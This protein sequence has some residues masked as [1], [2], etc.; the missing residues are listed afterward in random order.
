MATFLPCFLVEQE[1][2]PEPGGSE[3]NAAFGALAAFGLRASFT[4]W[5]AVLSRAR[6]RDCFA[7]QGVTHGSVSP[8]A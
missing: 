2:E 1:A 6:V 5:F 3:A 4:A 7:R 8:F